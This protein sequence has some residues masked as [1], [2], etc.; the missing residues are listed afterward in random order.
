MGKTLEKNVFLNPIG[1]MQRELAKLKAKETLEIA[2]AQ[3][4]PVKYL[5]KTK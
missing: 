3:Q 5:I 2:K 4:K 1:R